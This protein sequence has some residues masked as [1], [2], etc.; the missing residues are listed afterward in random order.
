MF[1]ESF[2][3]KSFPVLDGI[4]EVNEIRLHIYERTFFVLRKFAR[5]G[6]ILRTWV[7]FQ[8]S[9]TQNWVSGRLRDPV[10]S[11]VLRFEEDYYH[12]RAGF[13]H[14]PCM[15]VFKSIHALERVGKFSNYSPTTRKTSVVFCSLT[16]S[17]SFSTVAFDWFIK[18]ANWQLSSYFYGQITQL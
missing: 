15:H 18:A 9:L 14:V 4:S 8:T 2:P 5:G 3:V 6:G 11:V 12:F 7:V 17:I 10:S 1:C 13:Y 16:P